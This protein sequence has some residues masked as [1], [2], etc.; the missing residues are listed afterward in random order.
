MERHLLGGGRVLGD[1]LGA[2][3]DGV[4]GQL[5]GEDE[6]YGGLD[7]ARRDGRLLVVCGELGGLGCDALED[8]VDEGVED[9]HGAVGDTGVR[10]HLLEDCR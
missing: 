8:V 1:G 9:G 3:R 7:L 6:S 5:T 4:L 2:L 10:V